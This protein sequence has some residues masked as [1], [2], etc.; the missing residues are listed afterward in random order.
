MGMRL[1][2]IGANGRTGTEL[3]DL[4]LGRGH[5]VTALVRSPERIHR[6]HPALDV[7]V[8]DALDREQLAKLLPGHDAVCSALGIHPR[9]LFHPVSLVSDGARAAVT[10]MERA[11][12]KRLAL[13]SAATLFPG[14]DWRVNAV[15]W[16]LSHQVADLVI[17]EEVVTGSS[18]SWTIAR[19]PRLVKR[20]DDAYRAEKDALPKDAWSMS[21][22]SVAAFLLDAVEDGTYVRQVVG[23]AA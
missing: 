12:I 5:R 16:V 13:V 18:L 4:A 23:L 21:F 10:A 7:V 6:S 17:A 19:P 14:G 15:R 11:H 22:R 8:G 2:V 1:F 3:I 20:D 9:D